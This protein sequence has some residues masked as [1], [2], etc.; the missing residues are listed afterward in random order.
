MRV[1]FFLA[2]A[3]IIVLAIISQG[4][5]G[6][7]AQFQNPTFKPAI[8]RQNEHSNLDLALAPFKIF[9]NSTMPALAQGDPELPRAYVNTAYVAPTGQSINVNAG[10]NLQ[11]ALN[12]AQPG[13]IIVIQAG[14]T[15]IGNFFL[16]NKSG[17]GWINVRTS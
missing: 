10:G 7:H 9:T 4:L 8:R 2:S 13:D 17:N 15:F 14:A 1:T 3:F 16:P 5:L 12:Q 6:T 11:S